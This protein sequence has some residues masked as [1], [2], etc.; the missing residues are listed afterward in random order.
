MHTRESQHGFHLE[1]T[2]IVAHAHTDPPKL[3]NGHAI[4]WEML[5]VMAGGMSM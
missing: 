2:K 5:C 1:I 3:R 4:K